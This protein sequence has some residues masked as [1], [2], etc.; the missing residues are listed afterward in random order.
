ME[1]AEALLEAIRT[2]RVQL[3]VLAE[4]AAQLVR[5]FDTA[6]LAAREGS[7]FARRGAR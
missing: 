2:G 3:S 1:S 4:K 7:V 6:R 5:K